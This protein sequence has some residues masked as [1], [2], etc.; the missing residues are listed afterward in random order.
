MLS[1]L[2]NTQIPNGW[3]S[4][5]SSSSSRSSGRR[6]RPESCSR[7]RV[8]PSRRRRSLLLAEEAV[9]VIYRPPSM[10]FPCCFWSHSGGGW[11]WLTEAETTVLFFYSKKITFFFPCGWCVD[12]S[13]SSRCT[14]VCSHQHIWTHEAEQHWRL[15]SR[16]CKATTAGLRW[17]APLK[18]PTSP[19]RRPWDVGLHPGWNGGADWWCRQFTVGRLQT[20]HAGESLH[21]DAQQDPSERSRHTSRRRSGTQRRTGAGSVQD[22]PTQPASP[23]YRWGL[24]KWFCRELLDKYHIPLAWSGAAFSPYRQ[25]Q[26]MKKRRLDTWVCS[27][28]LFPFIFLCT[29]CYCKIKSYFIRTSTSLFHFAQPQKWMTKNIQCTLTDHFFI[30]FFFFYILYNVKNIH[31][32]DMESHEII[33]EGSEV[34]APHITDVSRSVVTGNSGSTGLRTCAVQWSVTSWLSFVILLSE[35]S[36]QKLNADIKAVPVLMATKQINT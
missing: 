34:G 36:M 12:H 19:R 14:S 21:A 29:N 26:H 2:E 17:D 10:G 6:W 25:G 16:W 20:Q 27:L 31:K 1:A 33:K 7:S 23:Q 4:S 15:F 30:L 3:G 8:T 22:S 13:R 32:T 35:A 24:L 28:F 11:R 18:T 9:E 5:D